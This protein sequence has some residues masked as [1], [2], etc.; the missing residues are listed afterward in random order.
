[1]VDDDSKMV[2]L[3]IDTFKHGIEQCSSEEEASK[4]AQTLIVMCSM[5]IHGIEGKQFK[6]DFLRSAI[7]DNAKMTMQRAGKVH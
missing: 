3:A 5:L 1:M 6:K 4:M 7:S 2:K